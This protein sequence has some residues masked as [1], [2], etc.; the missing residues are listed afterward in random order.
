MIL[1]QPKHMKRNFKGYRLS[2]FI[3]RILVNLEN[4]SSSQSQGQQKKASS[5]K[6]KPLKSLNSWNI[7][8]RSEVVSF[9]KSKIRNSKIFPKIASKSC[10]KFDKKFSK[11]KWI[12]SC[13]FISTEWSQTLINSLNFKRLKGQLS[14]KN[15]KISW[16]RKIY[17]KLLIVPQFLLWT[18]NSFKTRNKRFHRKKIPKNKHIR[19]QLQYLNNHKRHHQTLKLSK[20]MQIQ[21]TH[22]KLK[23]MIK[24][25][26]RNSNYKNC[27]W[28]KNFKMK[29][30][31]DHYHQQK[32]WT[33]QNHKKI[34]SF[35]ILQIVLP[36]H[37]IFPALEQE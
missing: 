32:M 19:L 21:R 30:S 10:Q 29:K 34:D 37:W 2:S 28:K 22:L 13:L 33:S 11:Q 18:I 23:L 36:I 31:R 17:N 3:W 5:S 9:L 14:I 26:C 16:K 4:S 20:V 6:I 24:R 1:M 25:A 8:S 35:Q 15:H 27:K 12:R 7:L